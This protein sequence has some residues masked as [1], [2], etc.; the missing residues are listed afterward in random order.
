MKFFGWKAA[1]SQV[2]DVNDGF[3]LW[4]GRALY[5]PTMRGTL[6]VVIYQENAMDDAMLPWRLFGVFLWFVCLI[7]ALYSIKITCPYPLAK[8]RTERR[9]VSM[10]GVESASM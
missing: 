8:L 5:V 7:T 6:V 2:I 4:D 10:R 1:S 9:G 3:F